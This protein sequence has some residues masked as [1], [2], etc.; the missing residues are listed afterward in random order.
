MGLGETLS[1]ACALGWAFVLILF[2]HAGRSVHPFALNLIKNVVAFVL[3]ALTIIVWGGFHIPEIAHRDA[4]RLV[5]SGF[6]GLGV[7]DTL[8]F[9]SLN[10]LGAGLM[11]IVECLYSP[12]VILFSLIWLGESLSTAQGAGC[13]L[14]IGAVT[15]A[16]ATE[17]AHAVDRR[18]LLRGV[19]TG[20][21]AIILI[22]AGVAIAKP[23]LAGTPLLWSIELR[24]VGGLIGVWLSLPLVKRDVGKALSSIPRKH[25]LMLFG[26][27][28]TAYFQM[29]LWLGGFKYAQA[30]IAAVLN[31][32]A[33][34]FTI[35]LAALFLHEPL[36]RFRIA[37]AILAISGV[38]L[39]T[40]S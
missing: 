21:I 6:L 3:F 15:L 20:A 37:A 24:Y 22:A 35:L 11:A 16:S 32:T 10:V 9:T 2:R 8:V 30:S 28:F 36:T 26:I 33:T 12:F 38:L 31:Q 18:H 4:A 34:I 39:I 19:L 40:L 1:L 5:L 14:V 13:A 7:A 29:I 25:W 27:S 17:N 23:A